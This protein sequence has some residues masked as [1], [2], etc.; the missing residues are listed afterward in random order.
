MTVHQS[1]AIVLRTWPLRESDLLVSLL[2][3]DM[4]KVRG[5]ARAAMKSRKRFGGALEPMTYV[6]AAY[7]ERPRQELVRLDHF[8]AIASPLAHE[9]DYLRAA[10]LGYYAEVLENVLPDHDPQDAIFRLTLAVLEQSRMDR[11][12][13]PVTYFSL[14]ITRLIGWLPETDRC[15]ECGQPFAEEGAY[16]HSLSDGL[17]CAR[18]KKPNSTML[19]SES[20][21]LA[22]RM[23]RDPIRRLTE[24]DWRRESGRELRRFLVRTLERHTERRLNAAAVF[25]R[26]GG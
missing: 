11:C 23:L 1:E 17:S 5:V 7:A 24:E 21:A 26:M 25:A 12:W 16:F 18:H 9:I 4:G 14:W 15:T 3:R 2:T 10:T 6:H 8:D 20:L 13:M 19:G 22:Q